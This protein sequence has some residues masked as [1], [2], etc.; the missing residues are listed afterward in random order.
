MLCS[1]QYSGSLYCILSVVCE[2]CKLCFAFLERLLG[3]EGP[4][5]WAQGVAVAGRVSLA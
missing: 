3:S 4:G 1:V 5:C 2:L